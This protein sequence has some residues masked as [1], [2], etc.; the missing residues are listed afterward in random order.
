MGER[1]FRALARWPR[2]PLGSRSNRSGTH[3]A[4]LDSNTEEGFA[5]FELEHSTTPTT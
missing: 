1:L 4:P 3:F 2:A 5:C